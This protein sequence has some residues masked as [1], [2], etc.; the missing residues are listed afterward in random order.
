V[1]SRRDQVQAHAYVVGRLTSALVHGE[2]DAPESPMRRTYLGSFGG[3]LLGALAIAGFLIWGLIAPASS[4]GTLTE[5]ELI[6][7]KQT[8]SR[9]IYARG[10][11]HPVLNWSSAMLLEGGNTATTAV[12]ATALAGVRQGPPVGIAGA[13]DNLP[14]PTAVNRGSW[15]VCSQSGLAGP[16]VSLAIGGPTA[17]A[18]V[19]R[20]AA[21]LVRAPGDG[22]YLLYGGHR[23]RLDAPWIADALG[24]SRSRVIDVSAA[25]LNAVPAAAD[26][27]PLA[28]SDR[29]AT[30]PLL[31]GRRT[32]VGEVLAA[33]NVGS[34]SQFYLVIAGG[35]TPITATQAAVLIN[36]PATIAAYRGATAAPVPVSPA[37]IATA[38]VVT[39]ML[40]DAAGVP[41]APPASFAPTGAQVPCMAYGAA[42]GS[43]PALVFAAPLT[44]APPAQGMTNVTVTPQS[45]DLVQV[46][47]GRGALVRPQAAPGVNGAALFLVTDAGVKYPLPSASAAAALGYRARLVAR[48]P[49]AL[50]GLL[51]TGPALDLPALRG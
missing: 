17:A 27:Q 28:V 48:L 15:L 34:A 47:P 20:A 12:S 41:A 7:V 10:E 22:E 24:L 23:L 40:P 18:A 31:G 43:A 14:A 33:S 16:L 5:G 2:P 49:A 13:P 29:G 1:K 21:V 6:V 4:P 11:L 35:V 50:L 26:L 25:W 9:Y 36:D 42:G 38:H 46:A 39:E 51:P 44:G 3:L 8:A 32:R 19:P 37:A 30:G 45:A